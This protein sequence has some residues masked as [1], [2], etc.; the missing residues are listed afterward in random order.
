MNKQKEL[1]LGFGYI[2][3]GIGLIVL[4]EC[5]DGNLNGLLWGFGGALTV[6]GLVRVGKALYWSRPGKEEEYIRRREAAARESRDERNLQLRTQ[7]AHRVFVLDIFVI[8][9]A[10]IAFSILGN[11]GMV[12]G[13]RTAIWTLSAL[14]MG[15]LLLYFFFFNRLQ[16]A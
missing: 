1:W 14:Q 10:I 5:F 2:V 11:L 12:E 6:P 9:V 3:L 8:S 7:A 13:Y 15:N 4:A 16:K